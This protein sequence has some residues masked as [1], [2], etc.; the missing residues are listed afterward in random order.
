MGDGAAVCLAAVDTSKDES[1][2]LWDNDL[3]ATFASLRNWRALVRYGTSMK[4]ATKVRR[5]AI[6]AIVVPLLP[7][8]FAGILK[9][10]QGSGLNYQSLLGGTEL[11]ILSVTVLAST[12]ND[13]DNS[14]ADFSKFRVYN[15]LTELLFVSIILIGMMFAAVYINEH[16]RDFG[17]QKSFIAN[18]GIAAGIVTSIICISLQAIL[19]VAIS[20][21]ERSAD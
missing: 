1:R 14:E 11:Y 19:F 10:G 20:M 6:F 2:S 4:V 9:L 12:K 18:A 7:M 21:N 5:W 17:M 3:E 8:I 13:L 16:V 15:I